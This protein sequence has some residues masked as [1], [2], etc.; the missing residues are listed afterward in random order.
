MYPTYILVILLVPALVAAGLAAGLIAGLLGVGGGIVIVPVLFELF[1][2]LGYEPAVTMHLAVGTSLASIIPTSIA[3]VRTHI[4]RDA[5]DRDLLHRWA[6]AVVLGVAGGTILAGSV[7]G[8]VLTSVFGTVAL[9]VALYMSVVKDDTRLRD[10]LPGRVTQSAIAALIG[11]FSAMMG[12]GGGTLTVPS[13]V[14]CSYPIRRAVATSSAIGMVIAIPGAF[15]FM[16]TGWDVPGRPPLSIG[17]VSLLGLVLTAPT[18]ML[19]APYGAR[20][21]HSISQ[22]TLR[23]VFAGFLLLTSARMLSS[24]L[25]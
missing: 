6:P 22:L 15:G 21:A 3:A 25:G 13:L 24:L 1:T 10:G 7:R 4:K 11:G 5:V 2:R 9:L 20:L 17:F 19:T 16:A 8:V 14:L 12:I 23:R 18:A